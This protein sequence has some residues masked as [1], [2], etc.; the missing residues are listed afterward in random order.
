[1]TKMLPY[2]LDYGEYS[3]VYNSL[4][5]VMASMGAS[6]LYFCASSSHS[7][8]LAPSHDALLP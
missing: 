4:S 3:A 6:T 8:P 7:A 2:T 1:M 5:F